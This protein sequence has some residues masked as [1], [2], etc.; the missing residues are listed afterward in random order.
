MRIYAASYVLPV[1]SPPIEGGAVAVENGLITAVGRLSDLRAA[2]GDVPVTNLPDCAITPGFVNTHTH[3]E[4]THFPAW[5][6]RK[7]LDYLPKTYVEWVGQVVKIRRALHQGELELSVREG[8]RMSLE[9]GTT[10][11]GEILTDF[12][13][14]PVYDCFPLL[15][16]IFLEAIGHDPIHCGDVLERLHATAKGM[17]GDMLPGISPHTPHTVSAQ[18]F[19]D[20]HELSRRLS[21][22]QAVHLSESTEEVTF[23]H[24]SS[25]PIAELYRM[26]RWEEYLPHPMRTTST[27]YLNDL[28]VLD[29]A[30]LAIH[31]VHVTPS[32]VALLKERGVTVVLC[33]R[34]NDRLFVGRAPH[35]LLKASG[36]RLAVGTDSLASNDS[37]SI[38]DEIR[39]LQQMSPQ[40]FSSQELFEMATIGGARAL[41]IDARTGSLEPGKR[42]DF[43]V[44]ADCTPGAGKSPC[45][46]LLEKGRLEQVYVAGGLFSPDGE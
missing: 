13:M 15:G 40:D 23:M 21:V 31:A 37:L 24:D 43:L 41:G 22:P 11:V 2:A 33:P 1:T 42:A 30:T 20:L 28:G 29:S 26:A 10:A 6:V 34:S 19:K 16:R 18:F 3:L 5:K 9:S 25:G 14:A 46:A 39:F 45:S 32:D 38:L 36:I 4:L 8:L 17:Q 12:S 35:H 27:R 7:D 44:F